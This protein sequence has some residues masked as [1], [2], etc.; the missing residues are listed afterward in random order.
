[1]K[2]YTKTE[3]TGTTSLIGGARVPKY[4]PRIEAYGTVDEFNPYR[5]SINQTIEKHIFNAIVKTQHRLIAYASI[6]VSDCQKFNVKTPL[7]SNDD[8]LA[9]EQVMHVMDQQIPTLTSFI[10]PGDHTGIFLS[11]RSKRMPTQQK[12]YHKA[13][14]SDPNP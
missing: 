11:H 6:H 2:I 9:L 10:L 12:D 14:Q 7:I 3:N 5:G 13:G 1:M 4:H 8:V